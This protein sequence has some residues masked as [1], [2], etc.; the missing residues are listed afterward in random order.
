[1]TN[2]LVRWEIEIDADSPAKAAEAALHIQ[3]DSD[4]I[5]TV[6]EVYQ[7]VPMSDKHRLVATIDLALEQHY[8]LREEEG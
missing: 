5:A 7:R 4:S 1:M 2:Y 3:R 6:F 8:D